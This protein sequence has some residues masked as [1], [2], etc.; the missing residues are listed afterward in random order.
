MKG[1]FLADV[2]G[3]S[4]SGLQERRHQLGCLDPRAFG[5]VRHLLPEDVERDGLDRDHR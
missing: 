4:V 5:Q 1:R 2:S 3:R